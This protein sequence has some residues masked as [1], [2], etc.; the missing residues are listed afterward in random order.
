MACRV[1]SSSWP[2]VMCTVTFGYLASKSLTM[3]SIA[4]DSRSVNWC[5]NST[6]P[7]G[8]PALAA[9]PVAVEPGVQ[10]AA[11]TTAAMAA[12]AITPP[13]VRV[14]FMGGAPWSVGGR[15]RQGTDERLVQDGEPR[16]EP[17]E[18]HGVVLDRGHRDLDVSLGETGERR[19][20]TRMY[21]R[22]DRI[23]QPCP[24]GLGNLAR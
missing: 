3:P 2:S 21:G 11:S 1:L 23:A 16:V 19:R 10:P 13:R 17:A 8:S 18:Q 6:V 5:Q 24:A 15:L 12:A 22:R 20:G 4:S 9:G 14:R 7:V